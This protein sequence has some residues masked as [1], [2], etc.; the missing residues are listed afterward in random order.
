MK[1][2]WKKFAHVKKKQYL[3]TVK[4]IKQQF[5]TITTMTIN[6]LKNRISNIRFNGYGHFSYTLEYRGKEYACVTN[7]TI[8]IDRI[9]EGEECGNRGLRQAYMSL[10]ENGVRNYV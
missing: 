8:S 2:K 1:K 3:C 7:D 5:K 4:Q 10:Y 6:D 9:N